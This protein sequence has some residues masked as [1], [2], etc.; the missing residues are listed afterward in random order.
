MSDNR[1]ANPCGHSAEDLWM[2]C[3]CV[4]DG[5]PAGFINPEVKVITCERHRNPDT[6]NLEDLLLLCANCARERGILPSDP[7]A[8]AAALFLRW[9]GGEK[10]N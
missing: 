4:F 6:T 2:V 5:V 7:E 1:I 8:A 9:Q 3:R 10:D